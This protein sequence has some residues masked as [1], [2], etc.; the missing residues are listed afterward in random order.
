MNKTKLLNFLVNAR[1]K[2]YAGGGGKVPPAFPESTQMEYKED[3]WLYRD[4]YNLGNS[5]FM[6]LETV[7]F[8]NKP[9]WSMCYYGNF[10]GMTEKEIDKILRKALIENKDT[11][12]LWHKVQWK[13]GDFLYTCVPDFPG[14]IDEMAGLEE[15]YKGK[16]KVYFFYY[17]GGLIG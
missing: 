6:G 5:I 17:A 10:K 1:V 2:T 12:R 3:G 7:Y 14:S 8:E 11:T 16:K 4:L 15:I 13:K 9:V